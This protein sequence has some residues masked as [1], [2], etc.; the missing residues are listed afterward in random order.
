[1][2]LGSHVK[3]SGDDMFYGSAKEA[4]SYNQNCFMVFVGAP[5]N[6]RRK[7]ISLFN[8]D[9]AHELLKENN[10]KLDNI[11]VHAPYIINLA[12]P[13]PAKRAYMEQFFVEEIQRSA[14]IG[15][16]NIVLHPGSAVGGNVD[17]ALEF[18]ANSLK[19]VLEKIKDI[20]INISL[21]TMAGKGREVAVTFEQIK[22][23][24]DKVNSDKITV[25]IDT[26]HVYDAGYDIVNNYDG[27]ID[28]F[29]RII[30][31]EKLS[32]IH[33]NDSK[34]GL[35]SHKDR[36]EN[37][38]LGLIGFDILSKFCHDKRFENI[39]IILETPYYNNIPPY[40]LEIEMLRSKNFDSKR[41]D[42]EFND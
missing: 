25:C 7:D 22:T 35:S 28:E 38:G 5:Q 42:I 12:N 2:L 1:M 6:S 8:I 23:I 18:I 30:G 16:K 37:V 20:D 29:D 40:K 15:A 32:V 13:D 41:Y 3:L 26:C 24:I 19:N 21:E 39:P 14:K 31:L 9:K 34:F 11:V 17:E 33:L 10:I 27:V 4:I 36:H